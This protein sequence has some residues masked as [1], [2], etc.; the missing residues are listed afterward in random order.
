MNNLVIIPVYK[1][2]LCTEE[3][4]SL[5]RCLKILG[6]HEICVIAPEHLDL[7]IY[8]RLFDKYGLT[9]H[10]ERFDD[11]FFQGIQGYNR[12]MM[13][14]SFY[15]RFSKW[16]YM[17]IYQLDAYVF[18]DEL[19]SW[20]EKGYDYIGAPWLYEDGK[21]NKKI[22]GNGGFSLR[23]IP[24][25]LELF[26]ERGKLLSYQGLDAYFEN[27]GFMHRIIYMCMALWG[28]LN[29]L[30][31]LIGVNEQNEDWLFAS[32]KYKRRN[33]FRIPGPEESMRFSFECMPDLLIQK[34]GGLLPFGCHAWAK[35]WNF[36]QKYIELFP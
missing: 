2:L 20:C 21:F 32:L 31:Y 13:E 26:K 19:D 6:N 16:E 4:V 1:Q 11:H 36:W 3:V 9:M 34:T 23:R 17:L 22:A 10:V 24:S 29:T 33:A 15:Q 25:F 8:V 30:E 35:H 18:K 5:E 12:L 27:R 28:N 7:T 14:F